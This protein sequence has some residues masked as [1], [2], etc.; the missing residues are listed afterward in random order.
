MVIA[1]I[2][3]FESRS[4][5]IQEN[6]FRI[7]TRCS[8]I[9]Y[10]SLIYIS[11]SLLKLVPLKS[12]EDQESARQEALRFIICPTEEFF[13]VPAYVILS[14]PFWINAVNFYLI[15]AIYLNAII[16]IFFHSVCCVYYLYISPTITSS[17][18]TRMLQ[19]QFF[20]ASVIQASVPCLVLLLPFMAGTLAL[21]IGKFDQGFMNF[22]L[23]VIGTHGI[24]ESFTIIL[25]NKT[26]RNWVLGVFQGSKVELR[27]P[28]LNAIN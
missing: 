15:P 16:Q 7:S 25:I 21:L 12:P 10:Y 8:R 28:E 20:V 26:Y 2:Y 23:I 27:T 18:N 22:L 9:F 6:R 5:S 13:S 14:D 19:K 1:I 17:P 4:S 24:A 3:L 11:N